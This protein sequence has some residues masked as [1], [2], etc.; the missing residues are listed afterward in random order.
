MGMAT[1][2]AG[3]R[4]PAHTILG[5]VCMLSKLF[6]EILEFVPRGLKPKNGIAIIVAA[7]GQAFK[8]VFGFLP[9]GLTT[10]KGYCSHGCRRE[11]SEHTPFWS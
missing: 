6:L 8:V 2:V 7:G 5:L 9:K 3:G 10:R 1:M 11:A 4:H